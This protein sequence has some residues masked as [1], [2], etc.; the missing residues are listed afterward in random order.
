MIQIFSTL[1]EDYSPEFDIWLKKCKREN[2]DVYV[3]GGAS[4]SPL[5]GMVILKRE[6]ELPDGRQG[7]TLKLCTFKVSDNAGGNR[8]GELL[9]KTVFEY[10]KTNNYQYAYFTAFPHRQPLIDFSISFGFEIAPFQN[11]RGE[12]ILWKSFA[13]TSSDM[14]SLSPIEFHIKLAP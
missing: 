8:Y 6:N 9:F 10:S 5:D 1:R 2:R 3:I 14:E 7:K 12:F 11:N 13:Y 4:G